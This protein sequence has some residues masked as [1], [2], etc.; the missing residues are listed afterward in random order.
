MN[1]V[2]FVYNII[3]FK[4]K[5]KCAHT[6]ISMEPVN[7]NAQTTFLIQ[8]HSAKYGKIIKCGFLEL[9]KLLNQFFLPH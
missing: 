3:I 6:K 4:T 7:K 8:N 5:G 9:L 1:N 2:D